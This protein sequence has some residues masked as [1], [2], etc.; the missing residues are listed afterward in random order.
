MEQILADAGI[1]QT[2]ATIKAS[3]KKQKADSKAP[4]EATAKCAGKAQAKT[5]KKKHAKGKKANSKKRRPNASAAEE[6]PP[7]A[8]K[9]Q[10]TAAKEAKQAKG[11]KRAAAAEEAHDTKKRK[12][13]AAASEQVHVKEAPR[14]KGNKRTSGKSPA[15]KAAPAVATKKRAS[16]ARAAEAPNAEGKKRTSARVRA[17]EEAPRAKGKKPAS[18]PSE[19]EDEEEEGEEEEQE[20]EAVEEAEKEAGEAPQPAAPL[21]DAWDEDEDEQ[22]Y[23]QATASPPFPQLRRTF[24]FPRLALENVPLLEEARAGGAAGGGVQ[25]P[26]KKLKKKAIHVEGEGEVRETPSESKGKRGKLNGKQPPD[27]ALK[28]PTTL[29]PEGEDDRSPEQK[30]TAV[31]V[32]NAVAALKPV[33][34]EAPDEKDTKWAESASASA[35]TNKWRYELPKMPV[36]IQDCWRKIATLPGT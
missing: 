27:Q 24:R 12:R 7:A 8:S 1:G 31:L 11:S 18:P 21:K 2:D 9:R 3:Q 22:P 19:E 16:G 25:T 13:A 17:A 36:A 26:Q 33:K 14:A 23:Y 10:A 30:A 5:D 6:A 32:A 20:E 29:E 35:K 4:R 28:A 34:I 15:A